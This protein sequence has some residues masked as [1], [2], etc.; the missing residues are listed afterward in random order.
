M[1]Y[2]ALVGVWPGNTDARL[3]ARM[4]A[5]AVKAAREGK[6]ETN[7]TDPNETYEAALRAFVA[8]LL[9]PTIS[10]GFLTSFGAFA[11]R[12]TLLGA[13]NSLS[14]LALKILSPG[15]PDFYQGTELWDLSLVDPDNRRPV[16]FS[17]RR[18]FLAEGRLP[19]DKLASRWQDGRIK[20]AVT[21]ALL[22]LRQGLP[23]LFRHGTYDPIEAAGQH[24][25]HVVAFARGGKKERVVVA[26]G[27]HFAP[28]T[29]GGRRWPSGWKATLSLPPGTYRN[30][31]DSTPARH[32]ND[33]SV[34]TLFA[35]CPIS[36][37]QRV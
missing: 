14:Q 4:Q 24:A 2:Q 1:L 28:L 17:A 8:G 10:A 25:D 15:V 6:E 26:V 13:L 30:V 18:S 33:V 23:E 16:D 19:W 34:A 31:F 20:L 7:W 29:D 32:E 21:H 12:T 36:V 35:T 22:A 11:A 9:D 37:M 3:V 27:R 5:Y